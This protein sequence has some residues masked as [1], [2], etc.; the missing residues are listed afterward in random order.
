MNH[1]CA[2]NTTSFV[3][4]VTAERL[5]YGMEALCP[6]SP[7]QELTCDYSLFEFEA[8]DAS[9]LSCQCGAKD[10]LQQIKGFKYLTFAQALPRFAMAEPYVLASYLEEHSELRFV[11][12]RQEGKEEPVLNVAFQGGGCTT[13]AKKAW[14]AGDV[15]LQG[16]E[17]SPPTKATAEALIVALAQGVARGSHTLDPS[18]TTG[19]ENEF[20]VLRFLFGGGS[21][22]GKKEVNVKV[23]KEE[24]GTYKVVATA[25]LAVG[26]QLVMSE[27]SL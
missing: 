10:C 24:K 18:S 23:E 14:A 17:C 3:T 1:S 21:R 13:V 11:D 16:V 12:L 9:I 20:W 6:I 27:S 19:E 7:G 8:G 4:D 26:E 15:L 25:P 22:S 5:E 2:P